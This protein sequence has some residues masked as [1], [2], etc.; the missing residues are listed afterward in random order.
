MSH[1]WGGELTWV[2]SSSLL[3]HILTIEFQ[4]QQEFT[5]TTFA[6]SGFVHGIRP[7]LQVRRCSWPVRLKFDQES[8]YQGPTR[9]KKKFTDVLLV[10]DCSK[11]VPCSVRT[12]WVQ[13]PVVTSKKKW[14]FNQCVLWAQRSCSHCPDSRG[15]QMQMLMGRDNLETKSVAR[16]CDLRNSEVK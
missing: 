12:P 16:R 15:S 10:L 8:D 14:N 3:T 2:R 1:S 13:Q 9:G 11:H 7:E 5:T 4:L 6:T